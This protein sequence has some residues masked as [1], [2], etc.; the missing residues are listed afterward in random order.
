M[1]RRE[2]E[3]ESACTHTV[4]EQRGQGGVGGSRGSEMNVIDVLS[5]ILSF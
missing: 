5:E 3:R 1:E 4:S 2:R